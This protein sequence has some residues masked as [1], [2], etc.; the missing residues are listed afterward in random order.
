[1]LTE[2]LEPTPAASVQ[3]PA[4]DL[5]PPAPPTTPG[6]TAA[7]PVRPALRGGTQPRGDRWA[8]LAFLVCALWLTV[9]H[10]W[11]L[12]AGLFGR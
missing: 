9:Y 11:D 4:P 1:M 7:T 12:V 10:L 2:L 6:H 8:L 3:A 5:A